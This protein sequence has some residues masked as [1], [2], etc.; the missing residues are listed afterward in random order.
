MGNGNI[1]STAMSTLLPGS[2]SRVR[3]LRSGS[4]PRPSFRTM[5][6]RGDERVR[7]WVAEG[8]KAVAVARR[9]TE[10]NVRIMVCWFC[11]RGKGLVIYN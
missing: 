3:R 11:V 8:V 6:V 9:R 4:I 5:E 7:E 2:F 1:I 10:R